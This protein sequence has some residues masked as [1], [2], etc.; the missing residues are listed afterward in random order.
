MKNQ[1]QLARAADICAVA[2]N[3]SNEMDNY[4]D[5]F[6][7]LEYEEADANLAADAWLEAFTRIFR[8]LDHGVDVDREAE[9]ML[10][11]GWQPLAN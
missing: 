9:A 8:E 7:A 1:A 5:I 10:R 2:G 6:L 3:E 4:E 11:S